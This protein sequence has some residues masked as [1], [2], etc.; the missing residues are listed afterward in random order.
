MET[1]KSAMK[2]SNI[3]SML[4]Q[5]IRWITIMHSPL[6][7]I[8]FS[9]T[10]T[11]LILYFDTNQ[12]THQGAQHL[13]QIIQKNTVN[14]IRLL[15]FFLLS[16]TSFFIQSL[17]SIYLQNNQI[18]D[19]GAQHLANAL[20]Q[21]QVEKQIDNEILSDDFDFREQTLTYLDL[22]ANEITHIGA[23][24]LSIGL[25]TNR[26][27]GFVICFVF[28]LCSWLKSFPL[29]ASLRSSW[30]KSNWKWRS[31]AFRSSS[32][33]KFRENFFW[34][35]ILLFIID[36]SFPRHWSH[37]IYTKIKSEMKV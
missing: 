28:D 29:D 34:M 1:I 26:V 14:F 4:W 5:I 30:Q 15:N 11:L 6:I 10:Q 20:S 25:F 21:N 16:L 32:L 33:A 13:A 19:Q 17:K 23:E 18:G 7:F 24:Y 37:L 9:F 3:F 31:T 2:E 12:I 22:F 36:M 35:Y 27:N 8:S